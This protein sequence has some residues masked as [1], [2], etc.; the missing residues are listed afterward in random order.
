MA[1]PLYRLLSG[2]DSKSSTEIEV[3]AWYLTAVSPHY[4]PQAVNS[5]TAL[6][7]SIFS[8]YG[9]PKVSCV[10]RVFG[11]CNLRILS[12]SLSIYSFR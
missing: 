2:R 3:P 9:S 6:R 5:L 7:I 8:R 11:N 10:P 12:K 1:L 4:P